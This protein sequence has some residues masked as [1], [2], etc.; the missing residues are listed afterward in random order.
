[1]SGSLIV[2]N[3]DVQE[4][5]CCLVAFPPWPARR[6]NPVHEHHDSNNDED[7]ATALLVG[8]VS[9][10][11]GEDDPGRQKWSLDLG[12]KLKNNTG[13]TG[14]AVEFQRGLSSADGCVPVLVYAGNRQVPRNSGC[15][16][17]VGG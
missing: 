13:Q 9:A 17:M 4:G 6:G 10:W 16:R 1:M 14:R 15:S 2:T 8:A 11:G 5:Q 3:L 12:P 7:D